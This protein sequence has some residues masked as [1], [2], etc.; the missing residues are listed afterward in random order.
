[1]A[2]KLLV[3]DDEKGL[4][5]MYR[6]LFEERGYEVVTAEDG[7]K[8]IE[9]FGSEQPAVVILDI[10]MPEKEGVETMMEL[11]K[12]DPNVKVIAVSGGGQ[13]KAQEYLKVMQHFGAEFT[14]QKPVSTTELLGAV[15]QLC[16]PEEEVGDH[17]RDSSNGASQ[18]RGED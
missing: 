11:K 8:G 3:I 9:L 15:K 12:L 13:I 7:N 18:S 16:R 1:M 6:E 4:R 10:I 2:D 17:R 5:Q 14:F